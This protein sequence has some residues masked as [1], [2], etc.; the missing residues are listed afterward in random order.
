MV[1]MCSS[2]SAASKATRVI[3]VP[4]RN[5]VAE[6]GYW[7]TFRPSVR[8]SVRPSVSPLLTPY[9]PPSYIGS[10]YGTA[11]RDGGPLSVTRTQFS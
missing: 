7:I 3:F 6:G 10:F 5:E 2:F 1:G 8:Q 4:R 11:L 9:N